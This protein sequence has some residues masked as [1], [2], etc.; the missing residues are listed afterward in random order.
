MP[1]SNLCSP[2]AKS[3][4]PQSKAEVFWLLYKSPSHPVTQDQA[5]EPEPKV[6]SG[7]WTS[8]VLFTLGS[9]WAWH[10]HGDEGGW[11][12]EGAGWVGRSCQRA[13]TACHASQ[14]TPVLENG[15]AA[16]IMGQ[17]GLS[18]PQQWLCRVGLVTGVFPG[19]IPWGPFW[20]GFPGFFWWGW[21]HA[22]DSWFF[23]WKEGRHSGCAVGQQGC[24]SSTPLSALYT[25]CSDVKFMMGQQHA[26]HPPSTKSPME[27]ER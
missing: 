2:E 9:P 19:R 21:H 26:Q 5:A 13:G 16:S 4:Q 15:R 25:D 20:K 1:T 6:T 10:G 12:C 23:F 27:V 18:H 7:S 8:H 14:D 3:L 17:A 11:R 22:V 24:V